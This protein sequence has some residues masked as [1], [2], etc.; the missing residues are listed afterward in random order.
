MGLHI[1]QEVFLIERRRCHFSRIVELINANAQSSCIISQLVREKGKRLS[2]N[3]K[4]RKFELFLLF[5]FFA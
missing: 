4:V 3:F 1:I 2:K 5:F